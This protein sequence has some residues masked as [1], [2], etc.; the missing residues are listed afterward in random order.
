MRSFNY[1]L[2]PNVRK[3]HDRLEQIL[4]NKL[5]INLVFFRNLLTITK[6]IPDYFAYRNTDHKM[7]F[8]EVKLGHEQ[9]KN[10]QYWCMSLIE[11]YGFEVVVL[12]L[13]RN[14]YRKKS[15]IDLQGDIEKNK[16]LRNRKI[17]EKQ[18]KIRVNYS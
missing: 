1:F 15:I 8:A 17:L 2:F 5:G 13:K 11:A 16:R 12:R 14:I 7:F 9:I 4:K 10:H 18:E 3:K 6:G